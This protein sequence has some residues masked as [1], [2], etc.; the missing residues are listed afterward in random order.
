MRC[1][2]SGEIPLA[3]QDGERGLQLVRRVGGEPPHLLEHAP[4]P[5]GRG[6]QRPDQR[7]E[8]VV[9]VP[10]RNPFLQVVHGTAIGDVDDP[11]DRPEGDPGRSP[12]SSHR[13]DEADRRQQEH[14][15]ERI[16]QHP[17]DVVPAHRDVQLESLVGQGGDTEA[18]LACPPLDGGEDGAAAD[19]RRA[20]QLGRGAIAAVVEQPSIR[21]PD[22]HGVAIGDFRQMIL[23]T[24]PHLR[25]Q[26][27]QGVDRFRGTQTD[28]QSEVGIDRYAE[29]RERGQQP[30]GVP[31]G[32]DGAPPSA[33]RRNAHLRASWP[34]TR[35]RAPCG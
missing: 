28:R 12:A 3:S 7:A 16:A 14:Y 33:V 25:R 22:Q 2:S 4:H 23:D 19:R 35:P 34:R 30:H 6:V 29:Q 32:H 10:F 1:A 24:G 21:A 27:A 20:E 31:Q 11:P 18:L 26:V 5:I 8:L 15:G 9:D 17:L 13:Q